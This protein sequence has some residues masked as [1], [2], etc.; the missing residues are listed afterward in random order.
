M[1][2]VRSALGTEE[3]ENIRISLI[4]RF[5]WFSLVF[6]FGVLRLLSTFYMLCDLFGE[7][8]KVLLVSCRLNIFIFRE[9]YFLLQSYL[10]LKLLEFW[11][12]LISPQLKS[13]KN[14]RRKLMRTSN[15]MPQKYMPTWKDLDYR[16][17]IFFFTPCS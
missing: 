12:P 14:V 6:A 7:V 10:L 5:W 1:G 13:E 11:V 4:F 9:G 15:Y 16:M 2:I 3:R 17:S 8:S